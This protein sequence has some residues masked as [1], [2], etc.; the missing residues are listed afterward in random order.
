M[1]KI[2]FEVPNINEKYKQGIRLETNVLRGFKLSMRNGQQRQ[3]LDYLNEVLDILI[4]E[5]DKCT[6]RDED[7]AKGDVPDV[8]SEA[9]APA[10]KTKVSE[11]V[12]EA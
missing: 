8:V 7:T 12:S 5:V 9:P 2:S 4:S 1:S 3:A 11:A 10:K 6:C